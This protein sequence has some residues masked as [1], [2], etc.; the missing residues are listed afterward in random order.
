MIEQL[1]IDI[2][3]TSDLDVLIPILQ[4]RKL[5]FR[6]NGTNEMPDD[7]KKRLQKKILNDVKNGLFANFDFDGMFKHLEESR[8]D[9]PLPGRE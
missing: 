9:R 4:E 1:I 3:N 2:E 5:K 6:S 8:Q 7:E